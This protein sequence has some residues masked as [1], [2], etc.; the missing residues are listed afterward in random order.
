MN[1]KDLLEED[2]FSCKYQAKTY[3]GTYSSPCPWCGG[4]DRFRCWPKNPNGGNWYCQQCEKSGGVIKYLMEHRRMDYNGACLYSGIT[5]TSNRLRLRK[6][7]SLQPEIWTPSPPTKPPSK[8]WQVQGNNLVKSSKE[9]LWRGCCVNVRKELYN[10]GLKDAAINQAHLGW[11]PTDFYC[12]R[13][14]WGLPQKLKDDGNPSK[15]WIP[16]GLVI[17]FIKNNQ[18]QNIKIRRSDPL[19]EYKYY[20]LP[21]SSNSAMVL[22][23]SNNAMIIESE[24][25]AVLINQETGDLI[26]TVAFGSAKNKPDTKTFKKINQAEKILIALDSDEAGAKASWGWWLKQ[27]PNAIRWPTPF[28]KDPTEAYQKGLNIR[29]WV[30]AGLSDL[31]KKRSSNNNNYE[32]KALS[33]NQESTAF[34]MITDATS[35]KKEIDQI[36]KHNACAIK[37]DTTGDDPFTD[38]IRLIHL[39]APQSPVK[40][41]DLRNF[42]KDA[43]ELL[44][45]VFEGPVVKCFHDAKAQLK[46]LRKLG[47]KINGPFFDTMLASQLINAGVK[48]KEF[49]IEDLAKDYLDE[50]LEQREPPSSVQDVARIKRLVNI[51]VSELKTAGLT[52]SA[53]LEFTCIPVVADMELNGMFLDLDKWEALSLKLLSKKEHLEASL[54]K[55]L[56]QINLDSQPQL[57]ESLQSRGIRINDIKAETLSSLAGKYPVIKNLLEYRKIAKMVQA[58]ILR[59]PEHVNSITGRI[60]PRYNQIGTVTGR[61]SCMNPNLQQIP[62]DKQIRNCF[63]PAPGYK[64]IAADYSQIELR[65]LAEISYD[66]RMIEAY[67]K[68]LDLHKLTASL[69]TNKSIGEVT[70]DERQAAKAVNFGLIY[71]MG[72]KGLQAYSKGVYGVDMTVKEAE[73]FRA[74]FFNSYKGVADWHQRV[75]RAAPKE[76]RTLGGRRRQWNKA[77]K[78][79]ELLNSPIQGT[80]ADITK[81]ALAMLPDAINGTD[82]KIIGTIH[83][84]IIL[85][86]PQKNAQQAALL[87]Q[88]TMEKAGQFYLKEIPVQV[89][90]SVINSWAEM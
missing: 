36:R 47:F 63:V 64:L 73:T 48:D 17:P 2:G 44:K 28:G 38:N 78:L 24:L 1:I 79:T 21:G 40:T 62:K 77:A 59:L 14:S 43:V 39:S 89:D 11:N 32:Y 37:I 49:N 26:T 50:K 51:L 70:K 67:A 72:A 31:C 74:R 75:N 25:D 8:Q 85:E 53:E 88:K 5:P 12:Q 19:A 3:G 69:V 35:L 6:L 41:I 76:T 20:L 16:T 46:F 45:E 9:Y 56:G 57:L 34:N 81:R 10:R 58:F 42:N 52:E 87:L 13:E 18:I 15:L 7:R 23:N 68:G 83:D 29:D 80:S 84:E 60:H 66:Q 27:F 4:E 61:F 54:F 30:M 90:V 71:A 33:I 82:A 65:I 22:G 86:S 55:K